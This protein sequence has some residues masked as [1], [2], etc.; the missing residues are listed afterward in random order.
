MKIRMTVGMAGIDY[1]LSPGDET[2]QFGNDEA[3]RLID[4]G[5][6]V[7]VA[8]REVERSVNKRASKEDRG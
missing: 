2:D 7:Q 1:S 3:V 6:A 8:E 4:A 5:Y